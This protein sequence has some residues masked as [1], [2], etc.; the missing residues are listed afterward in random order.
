MTTTPT[1]TRF[2]PRLRQLFCARPSVQARYA[3]AEIGIDA[4][5]ASARLRDG[6]APGSDCVVDLYLRPTIFR[7]WP[8]R[9]ALVVRPPRVDQLPA[10]PEERQARDGQNDSIP[11]VHDHIIHH[12]PTQKE[13]QHDQLVLRRRR[14]CRGCRLRDSRVQERVISRAI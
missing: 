1:R 13:A 7:P 12:P 4:I 14:H 2:N 6:S 10:Q 11:P 3:L 8:A 9:A 5:R